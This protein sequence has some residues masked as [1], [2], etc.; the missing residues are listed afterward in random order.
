MDKENLLLEHNEFLLAI[1]EE[2]FKKF[3]YTRM[4]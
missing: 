3:L 1:K 2:E 4:D